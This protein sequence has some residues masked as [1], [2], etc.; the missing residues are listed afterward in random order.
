MQLPHLDISVVTLNRN[1]HI[2]NAVM[3][4]FSTVEFCNNW[5]GSLFLEVEAYYSAKLQPKTNEDL[6]ASPE[7]VLFRYDKVQVRK[8]I[9]R[10]P[11]HLE[12]TIVTECK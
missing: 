9:F 1:D 5:S 6:K 7:L 4:N 10:M 12:I 3:N 8:T 11:L 2:S